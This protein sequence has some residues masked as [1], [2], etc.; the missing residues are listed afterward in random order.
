[1]ASEKSFNEAKKDN[2]EICKSNA[3]QISNTRLEIQNLKLEQKIVSDQIQQ[4]ISAFDQTPSN[5]SLTVP[6]LLADFREMQRSL[7]KSENKKSDGLFFFDLDDVETAIAAEQGTAASFR[8]RK[9][10]SSVLAFFF[11][12][13]AN[14]TVKDL[15]K[16]V[17]KHIQLENNRLQEE[18]LRSPPSHQS[19][20]SLRQNPKKINWK[21]VWKNYVLVFEKK[22][23]LDENQKL[24]DLGIMP[25]DRSEQGNPGRSFDLTFEKYFEPKLRAKTMRAHAAIANAYSRAQSSK[26]K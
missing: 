8:L 24:S 7:S 23:L 15:K 20:S 18:T 25:E 4:L 5:A 2:P 22:K 26:K 3:E 14:S 10:D 21:Y 12:C 19:A 17:A 13:T 6:D 11:R 16:A 9:L 1:M